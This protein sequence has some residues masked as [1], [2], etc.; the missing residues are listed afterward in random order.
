MNRGLSR[1]KTS[2]KSSREK[3]NAMVK[4]NLEKKLNDL[5]QSVNDL[6]RQSKDNQN[7]LNKLVE[8][9][10]TLTS[11]VKELNVKSVT[12]MKILITLEDKLEPMKKRQ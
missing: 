2:E 1:A 5:T 4:Q 10:A 8:V 6:I 7:K 3:D 12:T 11:Q 9:Q